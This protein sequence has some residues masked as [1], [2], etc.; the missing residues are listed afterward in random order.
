MT[1]NANNSPDLS[2][3]S[4]QMIFAPLGLEGQ[5]KLATSSALIVGV[6]GLG[7]WI[8]ELL[9]RA[10]VGI[11]RIADDDKVELTNIHRQ[12]FYAEADA[13][14][15]LAKVQAATG[16]IKDINSSVDV[17]PVE[18]RVDKDNIESLADGMDLIIDGTDNFATRYL[19]NDFCV[20]TN[21]PWVFGG[22]IGTEAQTMSIIPG[23][24][25][26]LRCVL[27]TPPPPCSDP[28]CRAAGV[29][30]PAV[31]AIA[32]FQAMEAIKILTGNLES[33]NPH[34]LKFDMWTNQLQ[35][36]EVSKSGKDPDCICCSQGC[37]EFLEP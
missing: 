18:S 21:R 3:F 10:G 16:R 35:R 2:R 8:A 14:A 22:V 17:Q 4:R 36:I 23:T 1:E 20:K 33:I 37:F 13:E 9:A 27:D 5:K 30:G 32:S 31:A 34:L 11:L 19:I 7:S 25:P 6:G 28:S 29:L 12:A 24:T 26:C 15:N